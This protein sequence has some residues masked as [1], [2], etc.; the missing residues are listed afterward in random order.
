MASGRFFETDERKRLIAA[1]IPR[2]CL[3]TGDFV[4]DVIEDRRNH[5]AL[6]LCVVQ[7]QGSSEILF[8]GQFNS[9]PDAETAARQFISDQLKAKEDEA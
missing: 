6:F 4:V 3:R 5:P 2:T 8:L 9:Q 7:R 1:C